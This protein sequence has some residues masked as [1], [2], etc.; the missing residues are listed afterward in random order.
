MERLTAEYVSA[1]ALAESA[2]LAEAA[3][4]VLQALCEELG[5]DFGALWNVDVHGGILRCVETWHLPALDVPRFEAATR[6]ATFTRGVGLPGRVWFTNQPAWLA[7]VVADPNF[8]RAPIAKEEGLHGAFA[9]PLLIRGTVVGVMEFFSR[10]IRKPD[11]A[12]LGMLTRVGA[13]VGQFMERKRAE[14]ELD[15]FFTLSLDMLCVAGFDGYFKRVN[16]AFERV[17]GYTKEELT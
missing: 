6:A 2:T 9:L 1:H 13:Q 15:R 17:L 5:W 11:E 16:P 10:E 12:L 4:R 7:D 3:T 8:P 14:E